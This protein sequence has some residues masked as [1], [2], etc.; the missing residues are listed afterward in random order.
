[1]Y[2]ISLL[3]FCICFSHKIEKAFEDTKDNYKYITVAPY[4]TCLDVSHLEKYFQ[5]I[6]DEGGE[7]IILR[8]PESPYKPGL[9]SGYLKYKV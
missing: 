1:M 9:S 2:F 8:D 3:I 5:D 6:I 4:E 7:G